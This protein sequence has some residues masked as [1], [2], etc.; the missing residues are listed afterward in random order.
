[1]RERAC[2]LAVASDAGSARVLVPVIRTLADRGMQVTAA[3]SGPAVGIFSTELPNVS[4]IV[5]DDAAS[6]AA[7]VE[8]LQ[9]VG[10][11]LLLVGAGCYNTLE[12][13]ARLAARVVRKPAVAVLDYWF[14]Y[15]ARFHRVEDGVAVASW[16]DVICAPDEHARCGLVDAGAPAG[17]LV[18]TGPPNIEESL[19]L[20]QQPGAFDRDALAGRFGIPQDRTVVLFLSEPYRAKPEGRLLTGPGGLYDQ[21]GHPAFGYTALKILERFA[22]ALRDE[23]AASNVHLLVKAHP[24]EWAVPLHEFSAARAGAPPGITVIEDADSGPLVALADVVV[25]MTSVT[26]VESA[27]AGKPAY[28]IQIGF[29]GRPFDPC[30]ANLLGLAVPV[31]DETELR[32][33]VRTIASCPPRTAYVASSLN[34][35][36]AAAR[37]ADVIASRLITASSSA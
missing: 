36:G 31:F 29:G 24:L 34:V 12:H 27:L 1:M 17:A 33:A 23:P 4:P 26:L 28:S 15:A 9:R 8:L 10:A 37:V 20:W 22:D 2:V 16:P 18:V 32:R 30:V 7:L 3:T 6:T 35:H 11:D 21:A 19:R 14:E 13:T 25:G 5:F